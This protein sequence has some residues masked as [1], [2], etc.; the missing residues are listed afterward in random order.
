MFCQVT[1]AQ[2][3]TRTIFLVRHAEKESPAA[4]APLSAEGQKRAECLAQ[5]FKGSGISQIFVSDSKATQQTAEPLAKAL[6][7]KP[8]TIAARD[9]STLI[10][11]LA[12]GAPGNVLVISQN[13]TLP[14]VIA[15]LQNA[16]TKPLAA[17]EYDR[18][19]TMTILEGSATPATSIHYCAGSFSATAVIPAT[20]PRKP[21]PLL[22][23]KKP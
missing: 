14:V 13:E 19:Y 8:A 4:D 6:K 12:Y 11:D 2:Q 10:R 18:L 21:G 23:A 22:P 17:N 5:T 3:G 9:T 20:P 16:A 1:L 15:R 7:L